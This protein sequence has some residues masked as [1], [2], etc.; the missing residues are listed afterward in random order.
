[1]DYCS[2]KDDFYEI[3]IINK[4]NGLGRKVQLSR[5]SEYSQTGNWAYYFSEDGT[6]LHSCLTADYMKDMNSFLSG[7]ATILQ[8]G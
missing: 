5:K 3:K 1:M 2:E 6:K 8:Y 7:L 4:H